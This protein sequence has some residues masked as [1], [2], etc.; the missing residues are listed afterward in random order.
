MINIYKA[1]YQDKALNR[2]SVEIKEEHY[3]DAVIEAFKAA[4]SNER[5]VSVEW[6]REYCEPLKYEDVFKDKKKKKED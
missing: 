4:K 5:V 1:V 6:V 2:R 3:I